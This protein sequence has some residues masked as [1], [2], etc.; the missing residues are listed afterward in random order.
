MARLE[1]FRLGNPILVLLGVAL[2]SGTCILLTPVRPRADLSFWIFADSHRD[3]YRKIGP[4][5]TRETGKSVDIHLI[6]VVAMNTR[7]SAL[8]MSGTT[9]GELP[10]AVELEMGTAGPYFRPPV[11]DVGFL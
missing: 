2:I 10:D 8:L 7:L 3:A 5:F 1:S 6:P 4:A 9:A 11:N